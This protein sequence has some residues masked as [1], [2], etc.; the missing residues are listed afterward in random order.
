MG[1]IP[2][3]NRVINV[4]KVSTL[5]LPYGSLFVKYG[6]TTSRYSTYGGPGPHTPDETWFSGQNLGIGLDFPLTTDFSIRAQT[7]WLHYRQCDIPAYERY[8]YTSISA[9]LSF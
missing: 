9:V 6:L 8:T 1:G 4:D 2:N 5:M 3:R 7:V